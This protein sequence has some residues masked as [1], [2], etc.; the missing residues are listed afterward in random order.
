MKAYFFQRIAAYFIDI[1][2]LSLVVGILT[3]P[4]PENKSATALNEELT[5]LNEQY[6]KGELS[7]SV[8]MNQSKEVTHDL[9]YQ[10]VLYTIIDAV[11]IILYFV[12]F[13]AYR[14]GQT[15]GKRLMH[16]QVV[17]TDGTPAKMNDLA[18]RSLLIHAVLANIILLAITVFGSKDIYF[19][20]GNGIQ[21]LQGLLMII[22]V[23]MVIFRKDGRG[24][25]DLIAKTQVIDTRV[26]E[27]EQ[28]EN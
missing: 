2:L 15:I 14:G 18:I 28:C 24:L 26:K 3:L 17:K 10:N 13:Q 20:F 1:I 7:T 21:G 8:Y 9:A 19:Y 22:T 5:S 25:H 27:M 11:A 12:I 4:I 6:L 16:I 23:F